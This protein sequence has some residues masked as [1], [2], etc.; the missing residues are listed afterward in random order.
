MGVL[1][2]P[3]VF[4]YV[5]S[6]GR[7]Y[8]TSSILWNSSLG[9]EP[10][11]KMYAFFSFINAIFS[12]FMFQNVKFKNIFWSLEEQIS[13][14]YLHLVYISVANSSSTMVWLVIWTKHLQDIWHLFWKLLLTQFKSRWI[15]T[16]TLMWIEHMG[17]IHFGTHWNICCKY[18]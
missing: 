5:S 3:N 9:S 12:H 15:V 18:I 13:C 14:T 17:P 16:H 11:K 10:F 4:S 1:V 2:H 7:S 8:Y 6:P